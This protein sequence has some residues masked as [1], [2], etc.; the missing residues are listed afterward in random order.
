MIK[1]ANSEFIFAIRGP[2]LA[3]RG[4]QDKIIKPPIGSFFFYLHP[5]MIWSGRARGPVHPGPFH[6]VCHRQW[7]RLLNAIAPPHGTLSNDER[8]EHRILTV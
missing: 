3:W 8:E 1:F 7:W 2:K 4:V 5:G 6:P